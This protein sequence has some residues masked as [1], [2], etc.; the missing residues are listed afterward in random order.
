MNTLIYKKPLHTHFGRLNIRICVLAIGILMV[1]GCLKPPTENVARISEITTLNTIGYCRDIVVRDTLAIVAADQAG[2]EVWGL[3]NLFSGSAEP[4]LLMRVDS[5]SP[6]KQFEN[7]FRV[8][9]SIRHKRL[10]GVERNSKIF[11][12]TVVR[13]DSLLI[14]L[15]TLSSYTED[16]LVLDADTD[17]IPDSTYI[18]IAADR[19]DGL[20]VQSFAYS[21]FFGIWGWYESGFIS[22]EIPTLGRPYAVDYDSGIVA[23]ATGQTGFTL[24]DLDLSNGAVRESF[25]MDTPF[26]A[27]DVLLDLPYLYVA[28][29]DGGLWIYRL[30]DQGPQE[31]AH[32]ADQLGVE[33]IALDSNRLVLSLTRDGIAVYDVQNPAK[34]ESR[35][36][37]EIGYTYS[38]AFANHYLLAATREGLKVFNLGE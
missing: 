2:I 6:T 34:P 20:K 21:N 24:Y 22:A 14:D 13:Y 4:A 15:E 27:M 30:S 12:M 31:I 1:A 16:F 3:G 18:L 8:D 37:F 7:V 11:P 33:S 5:I 19:D 10:F 9:Y 35:G 23:M 25:Q 38:C 32:I 17:G 28:T 29:D 36:I 26:T